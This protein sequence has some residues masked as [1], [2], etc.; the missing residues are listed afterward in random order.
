MLD[1]GFGGDFELPIDFWR[2][3]DNGVDAFYLVFGDYL[4]SDTTPEDPTFARPAWE[5]LDLAIL[6]EILKG[7]NF[8]F[9]SFDDLR[10]E[11]FATDLLSCFFK[12]D[13]GESLGIPAFY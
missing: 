11:A 7:G 2:F 3:G 8:D 10:L 13:L 1:I 6:D 5:G 4:P 9:E 12:L